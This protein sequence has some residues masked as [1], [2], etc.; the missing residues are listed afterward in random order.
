M[1][2]VIDNYDSFIYNIVQYIGEFYPDIR[3]Y[4]N[5]KLT[6]D[7]ALA[8]E[9]D[10]I[11]ISPGPGRPA[12]AGIS[13]ELIERSG[14]IPV[15]GVCLGH[16]GITEVFGGEVIS[17]S[18]II[19]GKSST[20]THNG[21]G[22]FAGLPSPIKGIRYHSLVANRA[23][24]PDTLEI[25]CESDDGEIMGL[26]V[27]G[28][29]IHGIQFHP[30]SF[31]TQFGKQIVKNFVDIV[32]ERRR[33][34]VSDR[35]RGI[36]NKLTNREDLTR[37]EA[38][39]MMDAI[40]R[41]EATHA[42][43][44]AYLTALHLKG[45]TV[46]E[47]AGSAESMFRSALKVETTA[48]PLIDTCGTGGD[49]SSLFNISTAA[50]IVASGAGVYVAKHGNRSVTSKS[51]SADVLQALGVK[52]ELTP[53][54]ARQSIETAKFAFLFAPLYHPSMKN[55]MP[56]RKE[57]GI[58]TIFNILGPIVNPA[59]VKR[60]VMGV[61]SPALLD[62]I[63]GVFVRLGH[64]HSLVLHGEAGIDEASIE[65]LTQ[66][67]EIRNGEIA[68]WTLDPSQYGLSGLIENLR[69]AG[70]DESAQLI[71]DIFSG[72]EKNDPYKA[73]V[74]NSALAFVAAL[75][76]AIEDGIALAKETI[77]SGKAMRALETI[78]AA[79]NK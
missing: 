71:T 30:E 53:E 52:I 67:R 69:V 72:A 50:A 74:L 56:V 21:S 64:I 27:K 32:A 35:V 45:E 41:G 49:H 55:V 26:K 4:R 70:A 8:M 73:V 40:M 12:D 37:G 78:R 36:V 44:S 33:S 31:L 75:D 18:R 77:D 34:R 22:I 63:P 39:E 15:F 6:V 11:V 65:G 57:I 25:T 68:S 76:I 60:H 48:A 3:V 19:H 46:D 79:S 62:L 38:S 5:D 2:L 58:R 51:G 13:E 61:A 1:I 10:G 42:Q 14:D 24:L 9:P 7:E 20:M 43:I 47:I 17:A 29:N 28:R 23:N 16:Q 66:V 59:G 54:Q